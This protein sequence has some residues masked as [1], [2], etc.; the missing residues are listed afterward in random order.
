VPTVSILAGGVGLSLTGEMLTADQV[1]PTVDGSAGD[2]DGKGMTAH[3]V[4]PI[5]TLPP[6]LVRSV[7]QNGWLEDW[8]LSAGLVALGLT[9]AAGWTVLAIRHRRAGRGSGHPPIRH[10]RASRRPGHPGVRR[11]V[12]AGVLT[13]LVLA[14]VGVGVNAYAGYAPDLTTLL[15]TTPELLG[16]GPTARTGQTTALAGTGRYPA[17]LTALVRS[18]PADRIPPGENWVYLPPGYTDPVN[19]HR[20]YPVVYLVHGWPGTPWDWFGAGRAGRTAATMQRQNLIR[21]MILVSVNAGAGTPRDTECLDSTRGGPRIQTFLSSALVAD[22]DHAYRTIRGRAGRAIG[23]VSS[24]GYCALNLGLRHQQV[25]GAI[26]AM[27][28]YGDPGRNAIGFMLGGNTALGRANSPSDYVRT[29]RLRGHQSVF[30]GTGRHDAETY[31]TV[32]LMASVLGGR[33]DYVGVRINSG[34]GHNWREARDELPYAL[35][36]ASARLGAS[37]AAPPTSHGR[38]F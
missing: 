16:R 27:M 2:G 28:P 21:P 32:Q 14:G 18:D 3:G 36:F 38:S 11:T 22:V 31:R 34:L 12:L 17:E 26:L 23:G 24:G 35:G 4:H 1:V 10:R 19:A 30:L 29:M 33:G 7:R 25:F 13:L 9:V 15:R 5:A 6:S 8:R 20:R 37:P